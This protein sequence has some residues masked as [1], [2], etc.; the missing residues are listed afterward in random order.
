MKW[1]VFFR[2]SLLTAI[3]FDKASLKD[4]SSF[5][6]SKFRSPVLPIRLVL[7]EVP[8]WATG[9]CGKIGTR[10]GC[11]KF[12]PYTPLKSNPSISLFTLYVRRRL[13][14]LICQICTGIVSLLR[15]YFREIFSCNGQQTIFVLKI[16]LLAP[17]ALTN[18]G[19]F[20]SSKMLYNHSVH[21]LWLRRTKGL[22]CRTP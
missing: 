10:W 19:Y 17:L 16:P 18:S 7:R 8:R 5:V 12:G 21:T 4:D 1:F 14:D 20:T 15:V 3:T 22:F 2:F 11:C 9:Q 6:L 13:L